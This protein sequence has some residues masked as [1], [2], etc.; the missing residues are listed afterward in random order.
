VGD[1]D[2][3]GGIVFFDMGFYMDGWRYLEA[4]PQDFPNRSKFSNKYIINGGTG[5]AL[6]G[7]DTGVG[8]GKKNTSIIV[9]VLNKE[10]ESLRAAQVVSVPEYGGFDD[11]FLPSKDELNLMYENLK[12]QKIGGFSSGL[13]WSSSCGSNFPYTGAW[14]TNFSDG[15][16]Q[17]ADTQSDGLIRA[18]RQF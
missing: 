13:Y 1:T 14:Q 17:E 2:P 16:V 11:C 18:I 9:S 8:A 15:K 6:S 5:N 4:A 3:A 12:K 10:G 7:T